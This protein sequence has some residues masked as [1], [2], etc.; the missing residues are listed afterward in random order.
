MRGRLAS[1]SINM[2]C[3]SVLKNSSLLG[4]GVPF[5]YSIIAVLCTGLDTQ[6]VAIAGAED[7]Q[8]GQQRGD[9][10]G[11]GFSGHALVTGRAPWTRDREAP[12]G[13]VAACSQQAEGPKKVRTM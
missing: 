6:A 3:P 5:T 10:H 4:P 9:W 12:T 11:A 2:A 13:K 1:T 8:V 7:M